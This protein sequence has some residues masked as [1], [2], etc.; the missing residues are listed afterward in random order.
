VI[1]K[2]GMIQI[3]P[4][5]CTTVLTHSITTCDYRMY[6]Y[7][8]SVHFKMYWVALGV[9]GKTNENM[10]IHTLDLTRDVISTS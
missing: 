1:Q 8:Y 9:G 7:D 10:F 2:L 6:W 4:K 5:R 3:T